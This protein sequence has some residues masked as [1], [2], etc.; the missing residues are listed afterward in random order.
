[1]L[2]AHI[3]MGLDIRGHVIILDEAHNMEDSAREAAS[4]T[5]T[6]DQLLDVS[7]EIH[8]LSKG[9]SVEGGRVELIC[10]LITHMHTQHAHMHTQHAHMHTQ[11]TH[12]GTPLHNG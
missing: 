7:N 5:L 11:H 9:R 4:L 3:K 6:S 12:S 10:S 2:N 1:M 8:H